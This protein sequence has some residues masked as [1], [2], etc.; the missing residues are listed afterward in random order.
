MAEQKVYGTSDSVGEK[1]MRSNTDDENR[2]D[3]IIAYDQ[4]RLELHD[5]RVNRAI[6][7]GYYRCNRQL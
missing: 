3:Q 2:I 1:I 5:E 7:Y 6:Y 4:M